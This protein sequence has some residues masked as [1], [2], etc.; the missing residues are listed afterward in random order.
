MERVFGAIGYC[1]ITGTIILPTLLRGQNGMGVEDRE[2]NQE[3]SLW[4]LEQ[5]AAR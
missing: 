1:G 5:Q 4:P 2:M 3:R